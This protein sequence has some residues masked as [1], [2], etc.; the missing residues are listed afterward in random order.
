MKY[1]EKILFTT[2]NYRKPTFS[3]IFSHFNSS[4]PGSYKFNLEWTL[5][6]HCYPIC[7]S[8]EPFHIEIM[9]LKEISEKN[10][11]DNNFF[12]RYLQ[13]FLNKV[14]SNIQP[15]HTVTKKCLYIFL[16][17]LRI[18][19]LSARWLLEKT[20]PGIFLCVYLKAVFR[21]KK[22]LTSKF[23]FKYKIPKEMRSLLC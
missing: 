2:S 4:I 23:T 22:R 20:I 8:M 16:Q 10:W 21:I 15:Q 11:Y 14:Y 6:F 7:C 5:I 13:I 1:Q 9:Q 12:H 18:L 17:Y 3:G 19:S